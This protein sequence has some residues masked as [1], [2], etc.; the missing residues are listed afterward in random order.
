MLKPE[1]LINFK[2][3]K[4]RHTNKTLNKTGSINKKWQIMNSQAFQ[5]TRQGRAE[6]GFI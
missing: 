3:L 4:T 5:T 6:R 2:N 1:C